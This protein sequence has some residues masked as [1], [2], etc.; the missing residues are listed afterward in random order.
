MLNHPKLEAV[1]A[2]EVSDVSH[3]IG[4]CFKELL[5]K[6]RCALQ[7]TGMSSNALREF[8]RALKIEETNAL[9][10]RFRLRAEE[11]IH[12]GNRDLMIA[13]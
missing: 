13:T 8:K 12:M 6:N 9:A 1:S 11:R 4:E 3:I 7:R 10:R 5:L 2:R